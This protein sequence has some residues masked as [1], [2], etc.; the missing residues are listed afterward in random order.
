M[1]VIKS[2]IGTIG[3]KMSRKFEQ[4]RKVKWVKKKADLVEAYSG[5]LEQLEVRLI[6]TYCTSS[7]HRAIYFLKAGFTKSQ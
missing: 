2:K 6:Y 1:G 7:H 4:K 3:S 5:P